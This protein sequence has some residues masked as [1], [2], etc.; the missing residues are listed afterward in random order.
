MEGKTTQTIAESVV[1]II[2]MG[3]RER[4]TE[5]MGENGRV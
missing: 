2:I 1:L 3:E 5:R 4:E